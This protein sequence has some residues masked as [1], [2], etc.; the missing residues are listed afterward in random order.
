MTCASRIFLFHATP[1]AM[2]PVTVFMRA[3]WPGAQAVHLLDESL[4]LDRANEGAELSEQLIERFLSLGE[5]AIAG[6]ADG[7]LITCSAFGPAIRRLAAKV[8]IPVLMPNEAMFRAAISAGANIGM[9]ATFAPAIASMENEFCEFAA[10]AGSAAR[11]TTILASGA[12][13]SLRRGDVAEHNRSVADAAA[14]LRHCDAI[15][16]AHFSTARS[17]DLVQ[18]AVDI[19]VFSA[20]DSAVLRMKQ[21]IEGRER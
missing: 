17:T 16:L 10:E 19:P 8:S 13:E 1:V 14:E 3:H 15:M 5:Q 21:L 6:S 12:I 9:V 7:I 2:D 11:L 4:S 20:P 18:K